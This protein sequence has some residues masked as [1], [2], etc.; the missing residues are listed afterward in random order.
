MCPVL[1]ACWHLCQKKLCF[2]GE[3]LP[4]PWMF[5]W[6]SKYW[7]ESWVWRVWSQAGIGQ[8][9]PLLSVIL[10]MCQQLGLES[11]ACFLLPAPLALPS[12]GTSIFCLSV[13]RTHFN[14]GPPFKIGY[15]PRTNINIK[16]YDLC[17]Y[18]IKYIALTLYKQY[19]F[20]SRK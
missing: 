5:L 9:P 4:C 20:F 13:V 17:F 10:G 18:V 19:L 11:T 8:L 2:I 3:H 15:F 12:C 6:W 16:L 14:Q 1:P 7:W